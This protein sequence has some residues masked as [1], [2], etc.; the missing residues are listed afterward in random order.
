MDDRERVVVE[1]ERRVERETTV[2]NTGESRDGGGSTRSAA[3]TACT[4]T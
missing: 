3:A 4:S 2:I 1:P